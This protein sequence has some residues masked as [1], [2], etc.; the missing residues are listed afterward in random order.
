MA[1]TEVHD[2]DIMNMSLDELSPASRKSSDKPRKSSKSGGSIEI[3]RMGV[4]VDMVSNIEAAS[5]AKGAGYEIYTHSGYAKQLI[6]GTA[7]STVPGNK[8]KLQRRT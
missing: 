7:H 2:D 8:P 6:R 3:K 4:T 5:W 1:S